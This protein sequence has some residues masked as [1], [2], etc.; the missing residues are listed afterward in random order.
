MSQEGG[1]PRKLGTARSPASGAAAPVGGV[2]G[3][4]LAGA[5]PAPTPP[6][7]DAL[8]P[9]GSGAFPV[10]SVPKFYRLEEEPRDDLGQD[11]PRDVLVG[12]ILPFFEPSVR[13][14][15]FPL[16]PKQPESV[17]KLFYD[18]EEDTL[19]LSHGPPF[20]KHLTVHM[21]V[22]YKSPGKGIST[23]T[24][25]F[26]EILAPALRGVETILL[27]MPQTPSGIILGYFDDTNEFTFRVV[28]LH[29]E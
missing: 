7:R 28:E 17:V 29:A 6:P 25:G 21:V 18:P 4:W 12:G 10:S 16:E 27:E 3:A 5:P 13:R 20:T 14:K 2:R 19:K 9:S 15:V 24:R 26:R 1:G 11:L 22:D 8:H 23:S